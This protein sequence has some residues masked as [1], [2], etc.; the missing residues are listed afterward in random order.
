M[1]LSDSAPG[2]LSHY[3]KGLRQNIVQGSAIVQTH[4]EF[5][6]FRP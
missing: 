3:G 5:I 2:R 4:A 1:A 6:F